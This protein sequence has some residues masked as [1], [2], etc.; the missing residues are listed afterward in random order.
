MKKFFIVLVCCLLAASAFAGGKQAAGDGAP[1]TGLINPKGKLPLSDGTIT[2][3][4][5]L[6]PASQSNR[7]TSVSAQDNIFTKRV[8]RETGVNLEIEW[9]GL[10][11]SER[12]NILLSTGTYPDI[13]VNGLGKNDLLYY[14]NQGIFIP[15]NAYDPMSYPAI[16]AGFDQFPW[17][18]S[19]VSDEKGT[20]YSLPNVNECDGCVYNSGRNWFY[21]PWI[22]ENNRKVPETL[23]EYTDYLRYVKNTD[24]NKN[25]QKDEIPLAF[26]SNEINNFI[27]FFAD[28]YMPFVGSNYY[29]LALE[30]KTVVEQ[31]KDP[32]FREALKYMAGLYKEGLILP[33]SFTMTQDQIRALITSDV[34]VLATTG[35]SWMNA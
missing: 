16:K 25:G 2:L 14:A 13:V 27:S 24:L 10:N 20:I 11:S 26:S 19:V 9:G 28:A 3:T 18:A 6:A 17:L 12:R 4:M 8:V 15:L 1:K 22:R 32:R 34:P 7:L 23:D 5:F 31:Y 21:N 30:G 29:G 35:I 33:D